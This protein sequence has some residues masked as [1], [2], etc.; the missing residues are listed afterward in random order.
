MQKFLVEPEFSKEWLCKKHSSSKS[1]QLSNIPQL[2]DN[3]STF[4]KGC[5]HS[6]KT[7]RKKTLRWHF[8]TP[9]LVSFE[10]FLNNIGHFSSISNWLGYIIINLHLTTSSL[11]M[12][13]CNE[14]FIF[15]LKQCSC[16]THTNLIFLF[17]LTTT[18][19]I[20]CNFQPT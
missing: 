2:S 6:K 9:K 11:S 4:T 3:C 12:I 15:S 13:K 18:I 7:T 19:F 5:L 8:Q 16:V 20:S 10:P 14:L 17:P 1:N